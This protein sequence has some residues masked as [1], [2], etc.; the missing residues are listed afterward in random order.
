MTPS[1]DPHDRA[2]MG[3]ARAVVA[4]D[5]TA[6]SRLLAASPDLAR[7]CIGQ[8]ATR[9]EAK[10]YFLDEIRHHLYQ[11][12]TALHVVAAAYRHEIGRELIAAGADVRARNRVAPNRC[13]MRS[14]AVRGRRPGILMPRRRWSHC[15]LRR[16]PIQM[17]STKAA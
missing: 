15:C 16:A 14:T 5:M 11:G 8:G 4:G 6:A 2:L 1:S 7:A 10:A 9:Q 12:D 17:R 13:T 3:F